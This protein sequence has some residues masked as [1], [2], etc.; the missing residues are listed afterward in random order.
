V[1]V[2]LQTEFYTPASPDVIRQDLLND[3]ALAAADSGADVPTTPGTDAWIWATA[4]A[5]IAYVQF[6][7]IAT[8]RGAL[9]PRTAVGE[10]LEDWRVA[11]G[12]PTQEPTAATGKIRVTVA[13]TAT[14]PAGTQLVLANGLRAAVQGTWTGVGNNAEIDVRTLDRGDAANQEAD[15]VVRFVTPPLNVATE[16]K[17]SASVPLT[18]GFDQETEARKRERVIQHAREQPASGNWGQLRETALQT[19][20]IVQQ[21]YVYPALGGPSSVKVVLLKDFVEKDNDY[22]RIVDSSARSLVRSALQ[23][24][25]PSETELIVATVTEQ[26]VDVALQVTIPDSTLAGGDGRGWIDETPWPVIVGDRESVGC[27]GVTS[28]T[29]IT[30]NSNESTGP[31]ANVTHIV[32]WSPGDKRFHKFLVTAVAGSIDAWEITLD[33]PAVDTLGN[34][35]AIPDF[36]S[37]APENFANYGPSWLHVLRNLGCGENTSDANILRKGRALRHPFVSDETPEDLTELQTRQFAQRHPEITGIVYLSR[38]RTSPDTPV[39]V[40]DNPNVLVPD[41]FGIYPQ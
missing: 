15:S 18:G 25:Y 12:V 35:I 8:L 17:V 40:D 33:R 16:A 1:A 41:N 38:S 4:D 28:S 13:G 22:S 30:V 32:W 20:R 37:P 14:I 3:Y 36:I 10:D 34:L 5:N 24:K 39:S 2:V 9:T 7:G 31:I 26:T 11:L 27:F 6:A 21:C 23:A 19:S 29:Q